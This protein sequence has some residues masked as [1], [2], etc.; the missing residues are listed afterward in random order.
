M[1]ITLKLGTALSAYRP[2]DQSKN[3][4][5]MNLREGASAAELLL[6]LAIPS[7]QPVML[8]IN[9]ELVAPEQRSG[10]SLKSGDRVSVLTPIHAG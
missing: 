2:A 1:E 7:E 5:N 4:F 3:T 9:D 6:D 10:H 8:I